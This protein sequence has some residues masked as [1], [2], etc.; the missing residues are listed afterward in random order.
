MKSI[1]KNKITIALIAIVFVMMLGLMGK[2]THAHA[3]AIGIDAKVVSRA[4]IEENFTDNAVIVVLNGQATRSFRKY[5]VEDFAE[6]NAVAVTNLSERT[7]DLSKKQI[8]AER[9]GDRRAIQQYIDNNMLVN[10]DTFRTILMIQLAERDKENVLRAIRILEQRDDIVSAEPNYI[11]SIQSMEAAHPNDA[12]LRYQ[13]VRDNTRTVANI[14]LED[15]WDWS[16]G[17]ETVLVGVIDTGIDG[18]HPDLTNRLQRNLCADFSTQNLGTL[19][20]LLPSTIMTPNPIDNGGH[21]T[22]VAGIIGAQ[23]VNNGVAGVNQNVRLVSLRVFNNN[24]DTTTQILNCAIDYAQG[25]NIPIVNYSIGG[26]SAANS[27]R[28]AISNYSGFFVCSTGNTGGNND[29]T[30]HYPSYYANRPGDALQNM[31]A[32][33]R[34]DNADERPADSNYGATTVN[35]FAPGQD[36]LSTSPGGYISRSGSSYATPH[37]TGVAALMKAM[38]PSMTPS[39]MRTALIY[40]TETITINIPD[41]SG[42]TTTQNVRRLNALRS[43][44]SVA[45]TTSISGSHCTITGVASGITLPVNLTIPEKLNDRTV[46]QI[47]NSAFANQTQI[48]TITIPA[49][50]T[51]IGSNS[52]ENCTSLTIV[53]LSNN[54]TSIGSYAF[55]KCTSL[56]NISIPNSVTSIGSE[57]FRNCP[58]LTNITIPPNVTSI[59]DNTFKDCTGLIS[60]SI[61]NNV[62]SIG[63]S[64]FENCYNLTNIALPSSLTTIGSKAFQYCKSIINLTIPS[65]VTSIGSNAFLNCHKLNNVTIPQGINVINDSTFGNCYEFTNIII[66]S[67][68]T[69]IGYNAFGGC[70]GLTNIVIPSNVTSI[71]SNAFS[72][73]TGLIGI[74]FPASVISIGSFAFGNC[75]GLTNVT[76]PSTVRS[77]GSNAFSGCYSLS[78]TWNYNPVLSAYG[79]KDYLTNVIFPSYLTGISNN[80]FEDCSKLTSLTIPN[81][82]TSIGYEAFRGCTNLTEIILPNGIT[83]I[84]DSTFFECFSLTSIILPEN[85]ETISDSAFYRCYS[86]T[87]ITIPER[88]TY[89]GFGVFGECESLTNINIPSGVNSI[90]PETFYYCLSLENVVISLGVEYIEFNAFRY[91]VNLRT[92]TIPES[93]RYIGIQAF[94][95]CSKLGLVHLKREAP[96][97]TLIDMGAFDNSSAWINVSKQSFVEYKTSPDL[98]HYRNRI[99]CTSLTETGLDHYSFSDYTLTRD[100][101]AGNNEIIVIHIMD[102]GTYRIEASSNSAIQMAIYDEDM[103]LIST[104]TYLDPSNTSG[105]IEHTFSFLWDMYY[106]VISFTDPLVSGT[107]ETSF[108]WLN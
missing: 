64:V 61:P 60:V 8:A 1:M 100:I 16:T 101:D 3:S 9:T 30:H 80:A 79:F 71:G 47:G 57:A 56:S 51:S 14:Q 26:F 98:E 89:M 17:S 54:L 49:S 53:T 12:N 85:L 38:R 66:P 99:I 31:I 103:N 52:F 22:R 81:S 88:V 92:V 84:A 86:L 6:I 82:V 41:G 23:G 35:I 77:V 62:T 63:S 69:S 45:F 24:G 42:G 18:G 87:T 68:V 55:K 104:I 108:E 73:C 29:V 78:I 2:K 76:I 21:G 27:T 105:Y 20:G 75:I 4:T 72:N 65:S 93:V 13:W 40:S 25:N 43:L 106:L 102:T 37:V 46:T 5:T 7:S 44:Q 48:S 32:V 50:V 96:D 70:V 36:I 34:S 15:A 10:T 19:W 94:S 33:G 59:A 11:Q 91:C 28:T 90:K 74:T 95:Y 83:Y 67:S 58:N 39:Q 107:V 97:I